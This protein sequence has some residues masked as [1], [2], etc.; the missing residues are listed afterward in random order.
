MRKKNQSQ[1]KQI[2]KLITKASEIGNSLGYPNILQ[3]GFIKELIIADKLGHEVH[4]TKHDADA[5]LNNKKYEYL[6]C[7]EGGSFQIDRLFKSPDYK[8]EKSLT[9]ITRNDL[10]YCV[11]FSRKKPLEIVSIYEV[12]TNVILQE[13]LRQLETSSNDISHVSLSQ[14]FVRP[15]LT[16]NNQL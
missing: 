1:V 7:F 14:K 8:K 2:I 16:Y 4:K 13:V 3:V 6:T 15:Y 12:P 11:V 10:F 5:T 9:R